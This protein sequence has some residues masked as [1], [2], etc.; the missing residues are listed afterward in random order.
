[1]L[2]HCDKESWMWHKYFGHVNFKAMKLMSETKMEQGLPRISQPKEVCVGCLMSKQARKMFPSQTSYCAKKA[3][4]LIHGEHCGRVS[5][6]TTAGNKYV[7]LLVDDY[8]RV[9]WS[10][11]I[12]EQR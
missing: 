7:F 6:T 5:P 4:E 1:M 3:L 9:I 12:E 11:F 8:S 2:T 10:I